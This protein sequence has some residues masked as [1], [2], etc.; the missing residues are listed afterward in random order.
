MRA[1][2]RRPLVTDD[3]RKWR[4]NSRRHA[5]P[6]GEGGAALGQDGAPIMPRREP[7]A[8]R[9]AS[10]RQSSSPDWRRA[11]KCSR[12][13]AASSAS[14]GKETGIVQKRAARMSSAEPSPA[15]LRSLLLLDAQEARASVLPFPATRLQLEFYSSRTQQPSHWVEARLALATH[16]TLHRSEAPAPCLAT[17]APSL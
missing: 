7:L 13:G 10:C 15:L 16:H 14:P 11:C 17:S 6:T 4:R 12:R 1:L 8:R 2:R 9:G 5:R 3:S